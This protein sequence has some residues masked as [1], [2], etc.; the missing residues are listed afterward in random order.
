MG[1]IL[2]LVVAGLLILTLSACNNTSDDL[3]GNWTREE[4]GITIEGYL[5]LILNADG[6]GLNGFTGRN[7]E[8]VD[9]AWEL[10][11]ENHLYIHQIGGNGITERWL[12]EIKDGTLTL[13]NRDFPTLVISYERVRR[14]EITDNMLRSN[15]IV[16][17]R[18]I[19]SWT[20]DCPCNIDNDLVYI[21]YA[22][23][24]GRIGLQS[25]EMFDIMWELRD[26]LLSLNDLY[27]TFYDGSYLRYTISIS[28]NFRTGEDWLWMMNNNGSGTSRDFVRLD[29]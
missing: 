26:G 7:H 28:E 22:D 8:V 29:N 27:L 1:K 16:G 2:I 14:V 10:R 11:N 4:E 9:I 25:S 3:V 17:E 18:I 15:F 20:W 19:G 23:G 13:T 5:V 12:F 6:T 24:T 21:F